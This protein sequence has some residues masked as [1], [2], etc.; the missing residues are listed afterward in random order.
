MDYDSDE[1]RM[2]AAEQLTAHDP[3]AA[4]EALR[5]IACDDG[6]GDEV[7]LSAA[8]LLP[9]VDPPADAQAFRGISDDRPRHR[10]PLE[11]APTL[12][13]PPAPSPPRPPRPPR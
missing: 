12:T 7:R 2:T 13:P 9:A 1:G 6:V 10:H 4:A 5:A 3:R 8:E 11:A